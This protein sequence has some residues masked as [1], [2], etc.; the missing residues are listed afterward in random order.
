MVWTNTQTR[1]KIIEKYC[2]IIEDFFNNLK[3]L[4]ASN[5]NIDIYTC[6]MIGLNSILRVFSICF[7]KNEKYRESILL[8][9]THI[10]ILH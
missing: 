5:S 9:S 7:N 1:S 3:K 8:F 6:M 2:I 4:N 10:Y